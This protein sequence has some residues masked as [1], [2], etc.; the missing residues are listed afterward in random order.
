MFI[1]H[2][3]CNTRETNSLERKNSANGKK[4]SRALKQK[5][6]VNPLPASK[7]TQLILLGTGTPS[8]DPSRSGPSTAIVVDGQP[9]LVDFGAGVVHRA[10]A[11]S[12]LNN[13]R[14]DI[15]RLTYAFATHLHSDHTVGLPDLILTPWVICRTNPLHVYGPPGI[16]N[17]TKHIVSAYKEDIDIRVNGLETLDPEAVKVIAHEIKEGIILKNK[18]VTITAFN[19]NHGPWKHA[20]GY[21]FETPDRVIVISGDTT[22]SENL[23][24]FAKGCDILVHEV[25]L[26][27]RLKKAPDS[28]KKYHGSYHTSGIQLGEIAKQVQPKLLVLYHQLLFGGSR[29]QILDEIK[30]VYDGPVVY[31]SDLDKF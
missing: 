6:N 9:Y 7:R 23:I 19:V 8:L 12:L 22:Y 18:N 26:H 27:K 30:S 29:K 11:A 17:M 2:F 10:M 16:R 14:L 31:G 25:Y 28:L 4:T 3:S 13:Y 20:Y 24:T 15:C 5:K 1:M 21:R